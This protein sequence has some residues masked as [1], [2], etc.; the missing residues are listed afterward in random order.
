MERL[1]QL[2]SQSMASPKTL[3]LKRNNMIRR[4]NSFRVVSSYPMGD[5]NRQGRRQV[6]KDWARKHHIR[7]QDVMA[8]I[9]EQGPENA[10]LDAKK[11]KS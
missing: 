5:L 8:W 9:R 10:V 6:I 1:I 4:M 2:V 7:F 11:M 3:E